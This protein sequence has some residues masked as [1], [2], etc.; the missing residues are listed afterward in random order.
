MRLKFTGKEIAVIIVLIICLFGLYSADRARLGHSIPDE[1]RY[2]QST[3][4]MVETGDYITPRYHGRLRFQKPILF[5][6]LI[7]LSYRIFGVGIFAARFPSIIAAIINVILIYLLAKDIFDKKAAV[8]SA[9]V[10]STCEVYFTYSRFAAPDMTFILFITASI[11]LFL[12]AYR[13]DIKGNFRYLYMYI[14]MGLAMVTK[15]PLG[16]IYPMMA[17]CLFLLIKRD[18]PVFKELRFLSGLLIFAAISAPWFIAMIYMHGS[19][20]LDKVWTLEI[21]KK[22]RYTPSGNQNNFLFHYFNSALYYIGMLFAR[23]LP[24]SAFLPA[25]LVAVPRL[26][27]GLNRE[28]HAFALISAWFLAVFIALVLVGSK[29]SYYVLGLSM[30]V[31]L[32]MGGY[33]SKFTEDYNLSRSFLFKLPFIFAVLAGF[34]AILLWVGFIIYILDKPILSL[35]LLMLAVPMFMAYAYFSKNKMLLPLSLFVAVTASLGFFAGSVI[36]AVDTGELLHVS[37]EIKNVIK[38]DDLVGVASSGI[39]Y[40]RLNV[41]LKDHIVVRVDKYFLDKSLKKHLSIN[42]RENINQFLSREDRRVFCVITKDDYYEFVEEEMRDRLYV[43]GKAFIWKKFHKQDKEYF[44][45]LLSYLIEGK[46]ELL[47]MALKEEIYLISNR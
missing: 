31:S 38:P 2:I 13:G 21:V 27:A 16:F 10:L 43:M 34:I 26:R 47:R 29:E 39:S 5:Y 22:L 24:W 35:S 41:P 12:K 15:G 23:H 11:Y 8:F 25:S 28:N 32:F 4:E 42:K 6:W 1:K 36:P 9:M 18:W 20:Y 46:R 45:E 33:F 37:G 7:I 17:I 40:H 44:N 14:P 3:K 19:E 30:P